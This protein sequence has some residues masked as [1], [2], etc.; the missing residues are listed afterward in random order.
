MSAERIDL[1]AYINTESGVLYK[2]EQGK[3]FYTD[4]PM[5]MPL[6]IATTKG[7]RIGLKIT[8]VENMDEAVKAYLSSNGIDSE[9]LSIE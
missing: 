7:G 5:S 6:L 4:K 2:Y 3:L 1:K 8:D 9:T